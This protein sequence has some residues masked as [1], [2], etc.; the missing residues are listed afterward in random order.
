MQGRSIELIQ[1]IQVRPTLK[2]GFKH[3]LITLCL[4][5]VVLCHRASEAERRHP[6]VS[7]RMVNRKLTIKDVLHFL[8]FVFLDLGAEDHCGLLD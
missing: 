2:Y 1:V 7:D 8:H 5:R 6:R 4:G 3:L